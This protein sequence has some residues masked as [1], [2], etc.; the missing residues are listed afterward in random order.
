MEEKLYDIVITQTTVFVRPHE[1]KDKP[2][3]HTT[4][5]HNNKTG[6]CNIARKLSRQHDL[7]YIKEK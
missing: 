5:V 1:D 6:A 4:A 7:E 2:G 3:E